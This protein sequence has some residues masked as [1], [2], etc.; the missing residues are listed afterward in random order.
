M[1]KLVYIHANTRLID[2]VNE[3]DYEEKNVGW[4][5]DKDLHGDSISDLGSHSDSDQSGP[6]QYSA[7]SGARVNW[8]PCRQGA[9]STALKMFD[10]WDVSNGLEQSTWHHTK[11]W[12][13]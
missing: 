2:K 4:Q 11:R 8:A 12:I 1:D 10:L 5:N 3:V 6:R 7:I 9:V 13:H